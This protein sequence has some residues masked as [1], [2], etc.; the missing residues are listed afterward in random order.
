MNMH[1]PPH[2]GGILKYDVLP[3]LGLTL[4]QATAQIGV[5]RVQLSRFVNA[6]AAVT[7]ALAVKLAKWH[8]AP[9]ARMWLQMQTD[10]DIWQ[11]EHG[12]HKEAA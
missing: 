3:H 11:I 7:P 6:R 10:Y 12:Q 4:T 5:S 2:P 8:S 9:T 1:N